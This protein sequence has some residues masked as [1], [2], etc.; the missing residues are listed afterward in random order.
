MGSVW[1]KVAAAEIMAPAP[2]AALHLLHVLALTPSIEVNCR[3]SQVEGRAV[4]ESEDEDDG[5]AAEAAAQAAAVAAA[6][7][8]GAN[9]VLES[10]SRPS[11]GTDPGVVRVELDARVLVSTARKGQTGASR[12]CKGAERVSS[13]VT[14]C[15]LSCA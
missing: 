1:A 13:Q 8:D 3:L 14:E 5:A 12:R 6:Q 4:S 9:V 2:A 11:A 15:V 10:A 7:A